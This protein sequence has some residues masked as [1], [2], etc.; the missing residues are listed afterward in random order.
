[1]AISLSECEQV[2]EELHTALSGGWIQKIHQ[3]QPLALTLDVYR[4][5]STHRLLMS[6][7]PR[8]AR[9]HLTS[10]KY[11]NPASPP[12][13]CLF[14]R[15]HL[16][17]GRI[18]S[19]AQAAGDRIVYI[20]IAAHGKQYTLVI[21]L[22]GQQSN[23][24]LLDERSVILRS[25]RPSRQHSGV[26]YLPPKN[27]REI[28]PTESW[29]SEPL[30]ETGSHSA[31]Q[32][33]STASPSASPLGSAHRF[34]LS[35]YLERVYD[36][37]EQEAVRNHHRNQRL[38]Q[39]RKTLKRIRK[40]MAALEQD[41]AAVARYREYGRYGELLKGSLH[42]I[43]PGDKTVTV[44]DYYDPQLPELTL[45]LD[46][47]KDPSG[48]L[49]E[50]FRKYQKYVSAER[51]LRPRLEATKQEASRLEREIF[52]LERGEPS[53]AIPGILE[54]LGHRPSPHAR[55]DQE[56]GS[57]KARGYREFRSQDGLPILVGKTASDN[58][59][60]TF[61]IA[62]PDDLWLHARGVPGSHVVI[63][64][65]KSHAVP[66]TTLH[67]AA[68]LALWYSDLRKSGRGEVL[69]TK[70]KFVKKAKGHKPGVVH[71]S[72]EQT[73]WITLDAA[74]LERLKPRRATEERRNSS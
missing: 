2:V 46:P 15:A 13:F 6:V 63:R 44:I 16:Q 42:S 19:V 20:T 53:E 21:A 40:R 36:E 18:H 56:P 27:N 52:A 39:L 7:E 32:P 54:T 71:V 25:L 17:G 24:F 30:L 65:P 70:R 58:D 49:D 59:A 12:S 66:S 26:V 50:Y 64:L 51:H 29:G 43:S 1:M 74:R 67:D 35:A 31:T 5:G 60:L 62:A 34:P 55:L 37:K 8:F 3:P 47:A 28:H 61:K 23:V 45:S 73:L 4:G 11:E 57:S 41:L 9:L 72:R 48:N 38:V 10:R 69:Y 14:L 33:F 68:T 22:I